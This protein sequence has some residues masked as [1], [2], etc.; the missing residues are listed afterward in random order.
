M[1]EMHENPLEEI[2]ISAFSIANVFIITMATNYQLLAYY[3]SIT[4]I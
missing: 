1:H 4:Y 3:F 2:K